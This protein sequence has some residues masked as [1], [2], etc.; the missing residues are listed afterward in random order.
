VTTTYDFAGTAADGKQVPLQDWGRERCLS[1]ILLTGR[2]QPTKA[3]RL[4]L[5]EPIVARTAVGS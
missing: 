5:R 1:G 3:R 2:Y 4:S